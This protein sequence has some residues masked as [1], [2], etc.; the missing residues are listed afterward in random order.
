MVRGAVM[1][2]GGFTRNWGT[3]SP[4]PPVSAGMISGGWPS[5][6]TGTSTENSTVSI[7]NVA[8]IRTALAFG[9]LPAGSPCRN[10]MLSVPPPNRGAAG[11][12]EMSISVVDVMFCD[13]MWLRRKVLGSSSIACVIVP[14][15]TKD[16]RSCGIRTVSL[17]DA[18]W[19]G[20]LRLTPGWPMKNG[21]MSLDPMTGG[22]LLVEKVPWAS[23]VVPWGIDAMRKTVCGTLG[24][25]VFGMH[26]QSPGSK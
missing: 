25:V 10:A 3:G 1:G 22:P 6:K 24:S 5:W 7:Q 14:A 17:L 11:S 15:A 13:A 20:N 4:A 23:I 9:L 19:L 21:V 26:I 16:V 18:F 2:I 12:V 8:P